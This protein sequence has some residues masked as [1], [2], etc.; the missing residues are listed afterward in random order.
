MGELK[1]QWNLYHCSGCGKTF[2]DYIEK[3]SCNL[4]ETMDRD[5][6]IRKLDSKMVVIRWKKDRIIA[7][8]FT[9]LENPSRRYSH[10]I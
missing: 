9:E 6:K 8:A 5:Y 7:V 10:G 3:A 1:L 2:I 4:C